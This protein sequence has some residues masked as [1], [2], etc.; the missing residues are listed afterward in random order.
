MK[1]LTNI[2]L[3]L[4]LL[5]SLCI[6]SNCG[7]TFGRSITGKP[8]KEDM[9]DRIKKDETTKTEIL[10]WFGPPHENYK[11]EKDQTCYLY[12]YCKIEVK[13]YVVN[14]E[15]SICDELLIFFDKSGIVKDFV[16]NKG[17]T[18]KELWSPIK[19]RK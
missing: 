7:F 2:I 13:A 19:I 10:S 3:F 16:Y 9:L 17:I 11:I 6:I 8:I 12:K 1:N 14:I 18:Q 5:I 15:E 4:V